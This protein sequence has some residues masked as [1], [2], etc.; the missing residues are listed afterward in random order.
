MAAVVA[1]EFTYQNTPYSCT[2]AIAQGQED[3]FGQLYNWYVW[4]TTGNTYLV[5]GE[6]TNN[7]APSGPVQLSNSSDRQS[8]DCTELQI[9]QAWNGYPDQF[10]VENR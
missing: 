8:G 1:L 6:G 10:I 7:N 5:S 2:M 3:L 4:G 9:A